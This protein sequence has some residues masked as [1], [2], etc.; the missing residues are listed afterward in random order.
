MEAKEYLEIATRECFGH[1]VCDGCKF[2]KE[3]LC[4]LL[5]KNHEETIDK[6]IATAEEIK[7]NRVT[8]AK[9]LKELLPEINIEEVIENDCPSKYFGCTT[10][11]GLNV[12]NGMSCT[13][14]WNREYEEG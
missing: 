9:K 7:A 8:Y 2:S 4:G 12:C 3:S 1:P 14:C 6:A 13:N 10:P 5:F 11:N